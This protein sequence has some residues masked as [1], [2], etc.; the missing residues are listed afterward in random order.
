MFLILGSGAWKLHLGLLVVM[1]TS[2]SILPADFLHAL[3]AGYAEDFKVY[4]FERP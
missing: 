2:A 4:A 3:V 1:G